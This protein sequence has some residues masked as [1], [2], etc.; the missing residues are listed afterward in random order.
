[1]LLWL[2]CVERF[3]TMWFLK[4]KSDHYRKQNFLWVFLALL[5]FEFRFGPLL[6][7][8]LFVLS[9]SG[10]RSDLFIPVIV[11]QTPLFPQL[12]TLNTEK[13]QQQSYSE[14]F[15]RQ[16]EETVS[17]RPIESSSF[18]L[19]VSIR[20]PWLW[21][22]SFLLPSPTSLPPLT[23]IDLMCLVWV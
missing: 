1:M 17:S 4:E 16:A 20:P 10:Q 21:L 11:W 8:P 18:P 14:D 6:R 3:Y 12:Q 2:L 9:H 22:P 23:Q 19:S 15:C 13:R 5:C 7:Q